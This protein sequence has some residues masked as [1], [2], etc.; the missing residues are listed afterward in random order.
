MHQATH[1]A[2]ENDI[3][4]I[5]YS[6]SI[7]S[8][9]LD[10]LHIFIVNPFSTPLDLLHIFIVN[11]YH[12][13]ASEVLWLLFCPENSLLGRLNTLPKTM[14]LVV[15][16]PNFEFRFLFFFS[17]SLPKYLQ[18]YSRY[19]FCRYH[20]AFYVYDFLISRDLFSTF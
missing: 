16:E 7:P 12:N 14:Q 17:T 15:A 9:P 3:K 8:T 13:P 11:P 4:C 20:T 1:L 6:H 10:L 2:K 5:Y 19:S 18:P